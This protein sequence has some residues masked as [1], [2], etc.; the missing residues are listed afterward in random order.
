MSE[1]DDVYFLIPARRNSKGLPFKN[2]QLFEYTINSIP[3]QYHKNIYVS[4]DDEIIKSISVDRGLNVLDRPLELSTDESS[5]KDVMLHFIEKFD[6]AENSEIVLLYLTYP[7]R[8]WMDILKIYE[9]YKDNNATSL[10]CAEEITEHPYLCLYEKDDLRGELVVDHD[11]YRR[12]DYPKVFKHSLYVGC[13]NSTIIE[14]LHD[15]LINED[16]IYYKMDNKVDVDT[17]D[18]LK[19]YLNDE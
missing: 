11:L 7:E 14:S 19:K 2:R 16:T 3:D 15:L 17:S 6:I 4:T 18:D 9:F 5:V 8:T 12:Q 1:I 13:Y 10:I